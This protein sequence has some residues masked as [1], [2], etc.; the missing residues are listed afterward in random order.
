MLTKIFEDKDVH[1]L[2][3]YINR[4]ERFVIITHVTPDGDAIGSSLG[5]YHFL[6]VM[7]K[8]SVNIVV[9]NDFPS[10]LKWMP[11]ATDIVVYER[12]KE[13]AER[14]LREADIIF[15]L[16]FNELKR[17]GKLA[18]FLEAADGRKVLIDHH[19]E[20]APFCRLILSCPEMSS[21]SE[22]VFRLLC[23]IKSFSDINKDAAECI[24]AGMMTDTGSFT[25]GS[26][27][28]EL[29]YIIT[30]LLKK[31]I[32][33]D[34]IYRKVY[35]VYAE[36]RLRLMG[37]SLYE[38]MKIYPEQKTAMIVLS[39]KE[40][41]RFNY[42]T[43]D[44]EGFVNLPLSIEDIQFSVLIREDTDNIKMSFRSV[45]DFPT[46]RFSSTY[47]HGGGHK[48]ASGG[49]FYGSLSDAVIAFETAIQEMNP[50]NYRP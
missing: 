19:P 22:M 47:F 20:T 28:P 38:K 36:S 29:Y 11:G 45:S 49:E 17:I 12:S 24:Y 14:L 7:G 42:T 30:E 6:S 21:T 3:T 26:N 25:F 37:Y 39:L 23:A 32:D 50:T 4:G 43:G 48:N 15:C 1:V 10:F 40:L 31:G 18:P 41:N 5:L 9:P 13:Y 34:M 33:K 46:N 44:T 2:E 16:D 35:Q 27:N 8:D